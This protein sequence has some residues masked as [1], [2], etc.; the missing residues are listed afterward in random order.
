MPTRGKSSSGEST[1]RVAD[2]TQA[3]RGIRVPITRRTKLQ[4]L[5][6]QEDDPSGPETEEEH[7]VMTPSE[8]G[9]KGISHGMSPH[10]RGVL[11][12]QARW[13]KVHAAQE[14]QKEVPEKGKG[15]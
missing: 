4:N 14:S 5:S 15:G 8:R 6:L 2:T 11:G 10:D 7:H 1:P 9:K 3:A 13:A 12:A